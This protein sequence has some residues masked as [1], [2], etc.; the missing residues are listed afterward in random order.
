MTDLEGLF[1]ASPAITFRE[2]THLGC[3]RGPPEVREIWPGTV[4]FGPGTVKLRPGTVKLS[5][6]RETQQE[7]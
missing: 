5:R 1:W 6:N 3:S 2:S 4:K 7:P